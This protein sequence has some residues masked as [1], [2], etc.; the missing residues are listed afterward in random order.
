MFSNID[1]YGEN[2]LIGLNLLEKE[3]KGGVTS[4]YDI[5]MIK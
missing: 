3:D 2:F 1:A 4:R 5:K